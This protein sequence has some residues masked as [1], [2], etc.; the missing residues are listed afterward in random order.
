[1]HIERLWV[2]SCIVVWK[3][4]GLFLKPTEGTECW[5][6][7]PRY[8]PLVEKSVCGLFLG[9]LYAQGFPAG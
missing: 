5:G 3:P 7:R 4:S 2:E 6:A 9:R 1:M 8:V